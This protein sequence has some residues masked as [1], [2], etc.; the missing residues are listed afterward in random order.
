MYTLEYRIHLMLNKNDLSGTSL[1]V[2]WLR[3]PSN[4]G[5]AGS[6]LGQ[7]AEIP[8]ALQPKTIKA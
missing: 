1:V 5:G 2:Q 3:P 7:G 4:A 8:H 6:I